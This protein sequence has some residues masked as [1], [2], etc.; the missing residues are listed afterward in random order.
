[1]LRQGVGAQALAKVV[2]FDPED[3]VIALGLT[4]YLK[5]IILFSTAYR[6]K[7]WRCRLNARR[8]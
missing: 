6:A 4:I 2:R 1:M 7:D 8:P 3:G 5:S